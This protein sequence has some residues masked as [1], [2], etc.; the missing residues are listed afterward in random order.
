MCGSAF[1]NRFLSSVVGQHGLD[2]MACSPITGSLKI[3]FV[4]IGDFRAWST[5]SRHSA[6]VSRKRR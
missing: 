1:S 4:A 2:A 3:G 6:A 5:T